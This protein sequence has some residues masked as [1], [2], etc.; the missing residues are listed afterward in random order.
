MDYGVP[1]IP[2]LVDDAIMPR[3]HD[4][5]ADIK[6]FATLRPWMQAKISEFIWS[7]CSVISTKS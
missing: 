7:V 6:N 1:M 3:A 4:P 2:V 5:P